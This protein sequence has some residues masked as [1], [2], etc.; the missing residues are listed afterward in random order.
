MPKKPRVLVVDDLADTAE[1]LASVLNALGH[2]AAWLTNPSEV[3]DAV[4]R[5]RPHLVFLDL[6]MPEMDG[7]RLARMLRAEHGFESLRLVALTGHGYEEDRVACRRAGFDAHVSKPAGRK[8]V[9]TVLETVLAD[10]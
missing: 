9:E 6:E 4:R 2:D 3:M 10:R 8:M 1:A 5:F 7:Y